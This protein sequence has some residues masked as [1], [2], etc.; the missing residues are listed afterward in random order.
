[1][2][3]NLLDRLD[4]AIKELQSIRD[5]LDD[6]QLDHRSDRW[7]DDIDT[8][9]RD[10]RTHPLSQLCREVKKVRKAAGRSWTAESKATIRNT[11]GNYDPQS[12]H[13]VGPARYERVSRG[14]WKAI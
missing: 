8:V 12:K 3:L 10:G 14:M 9:I 1:M 7:V 11:L 6:Q 5:E 2:K 13:F 4:A